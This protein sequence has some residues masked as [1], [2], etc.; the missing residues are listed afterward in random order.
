MFYPANSWSLVGLS[1]YFVSFLQIL[2]EKNI[3]DK[4]NADIAE[5]DN[6][7]CHQNMHFK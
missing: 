6:Y 2:H 5:K 7:I 4:L 3:T 1:N